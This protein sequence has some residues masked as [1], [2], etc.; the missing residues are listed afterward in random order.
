MRVCLSV[1]RAKEKRRGEKEGHNMRQR[2][3]EQTIGIEGRPRMR[4]V[5]KASNGLGA[6]S[7]NA[8]RATTVLDGAGAV[9]ESF[10]SEVAAASA[11][12]DC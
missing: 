5:P 3:T 11:D 1:V 4:T 9:A 12:V 10:I 8:D 7:A 2:G 6:A